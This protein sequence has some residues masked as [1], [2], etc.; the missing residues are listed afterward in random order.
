V[1]D[2]S[3]LFLILVASVIIITNS[4]NT[5]VLSQSGGGECDPSWQ[6]GQCLFDAN[7]K[8]YYDI[9]NCSEQPGS[10]GKPGYVTHCI[11]VVTNGTTSHIG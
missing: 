9:D 11:N 1:K 6:R 2:L 8:Y 10:S 5:F 3:K 4:V 7:G